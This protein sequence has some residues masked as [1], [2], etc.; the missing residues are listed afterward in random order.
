MN[1]FNLAVDPW[2]PV[3]DGQ[4]V[5]EVSLTTC[6]TAA[7][8]FAGLA[9]DAPL[10]TVALFRQVVLPAYIDAVFQEPGC[11]PPADADQWAELWATESLD[12][13]PSWYAGSDTA[14][15]PITSYLQ[16]QHDRFEVFGD[17]PFA[18]V[19]GLRTSS[20]ATKPVSLLMASIATGNSVPLFSARTDDDPPALSPAA[21][22]RAVL[23]AHC[24]D[25]AGIKSGAVGDPQVKAGKTT[26]NQTGPAG[27][28]G[29]V[30]P[31]GRTL[32]ETILL[33]LRCSSDAD[34]A[35]RPQWRRAD[36]GEAGPKWKTRATSGL[37]DLLTWQGRRIRLIPEQDDGGIR[38]RQVV[39]CAGDRLDGGTPQIEPHCAWRMSKQT[40]RQIPVRHTAGR[41]AWRGMLPML[42]ASGRAT[43]HGSSSRTLVHVR[44][45]QYSGALPADYPLRVLC[46][47]LVYGTQNAVVEDIVTDLLP[48][49]MAAL[50][51]SGEAYQLVEEIVQQAEELRQAVNRLS[52]D[53]RAAAGGDRLP[54]ERGQRVGDRMMHAFDRPARQALNALQNDPAEAE[55]IRNDWI[56]TARGIVWKTA[57]PVLSGAAPQSFLGRAEKNQPRQRAATAE[58]WFRIAVTK[59]LGQP[60][61]EVAG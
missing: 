23:S 26:G 9:L 38:V 24:W 60:D 57:E 17:S 27:A 14:D 22:I 4:G 36:T 56:R 18:Q 48:M 58:R 20:G 42:A 29:A 8:R 2:V 1:G 53:L 16:R 52:D 59:T 37:L 35:D 45:M 46:V 50:D 43:T 7:Q 31:L 21:A 28:I 3:L 47:G 13:W 15:P 49:P 55:A 10:E 30:I 25:T 51:D 19:G 44:E 41:A 11:P 33:H 5:I 32:K 6:L 40:K 39:L 12:V 34:P 54:W 61:G